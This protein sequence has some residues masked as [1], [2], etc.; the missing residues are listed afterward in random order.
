[1]LELVGSQSLPHV[2]KR[3]CIL[4]LPWMGVASFD[5]GILAMLLKL[6]WLSADA[7]LLMINL[8]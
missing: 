5:L 8:L 1:M 6:L 4:L 3:V 2:G 7:W